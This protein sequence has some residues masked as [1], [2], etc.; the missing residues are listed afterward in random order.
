MHD[1]ARKPEPS[2]GESS[3]TTTMPPRIRTVTRSWRGSSATKVEPRRR[4]AW[5]RAEG[6][7]AAARPN[8]Q[9]DAWAGTP[10]SVT[11]WTCPSS[12]LGSRRK[13]RST[14]SGMRKARASPARVRSCRGA[15]T[16]SASCH[17]SKR[18]S[19]K[20]SLSLLAFRRSSDHPQPRTRSRYPVWPPASAPG[21]SDMSAPRV[22]ARPEVRPSPARR[23]PRGDAH[24][25]RLEAMPTQI[26]PAPATGKGAELR[27]GKP[28]R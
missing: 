28:D 8:L 12:S 26:E 24:Q 14:W 7:I 13:A 18:R 20:I 3:A 21:A 11:R 2:G 1:Q 22:A 16:P 10:P 19:S 15:S 6:R 27:W 25:V 9:L 5:M 17:R 4:R 23:R